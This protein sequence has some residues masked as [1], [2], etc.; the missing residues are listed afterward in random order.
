VESR[1]HQ[2]LTPCLP[3]ASEPKDIASEPFPSTYGEPVAY[4]PF[5]RSEACHLR[6][7]ENAMLRGSDA[8]H[9]QVQAFLCLIGNLGVSHEAQ[10]LT[11]L[12]LARG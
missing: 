12:Q 1:G 7:R 9:L 6:T 4:G 2:G 11:R 5:R 10:E 8:R 3:G